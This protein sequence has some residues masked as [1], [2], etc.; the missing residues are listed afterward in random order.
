MSNE[1]H[2][3]ITLLAFTG[4]V[5]ITSPLVAQDFG[6]LSKDQRK[7]FL[8]AYAEIDAIDQLVPLCDEIAPGYSAPNQAAMAEFKEARSIDEARSLVD[9]YIAWQ[10]AESS[11]TE[12]ALALT[13]GLTRKAIRASLE[14]EPEK[15]GDSFKAEIFDTAFSS[16]AGLVETYGLDAGA[17]DV[18]EAAPAPA[19]AD[20]V[21]SFVPAKRPAAE[22]AK[23]ATAAAAGDV[24]MPAPIGDRLEELPGISWQ[25]IDGVRNANSG[26]AFCVWRCVS[27]EYDDGDYHYPQL[28]VHEAVPLGADE[29]IDQMLALTDEYEVIEQEQLDSAGYAPQMA[30]QPDRLA[31][32]NMLVD[33]LGDA[34]RHVLFALEK[35][36]LTTIAQLRYSEDYKTSEEAQ[37]ALTYTVTQLQMDPAIVTADLAAN[38]GGMTVDAAKGAPPATGQVI[39]AETPNSSVNALTLSLSYDDDVRYLDETVL[40]DQGSVVDMNDTTYYYVP[41]Q[42]D[43]VTIEGVF[44]SADGYAG[45]GISVLK[46]DTLVFNRNGRYMTSAS[47]GVVGGFLAS[48][49]SSSEGQGSYRINGYTLKLQS[50]DGAVQSDVF[51]PYLSRTFWPGSD[52]PA[53]EVNFINVG[54]KILYR[55]DG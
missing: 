29:A 55:D 23:A 24:G 48:S 43:G 5:F 54:G 37:K 26:G 45:V 52:G 49:G 27:L 9:D 41:P 6:T 34:D 47:S 36:G 21:T 25:A 10:K 40:E 2:R 3:R 22:P 8:G 35:N 30:M 13:L 53:D 7:Q 32:R 14:K 33:H 17:A 39:F 11:T 19:P 16:V 28:I 44:T 50:D 1:F 18:A 42:P 31:I 4:A 38:P 46:S 12:A 51:F 15:C 20:E